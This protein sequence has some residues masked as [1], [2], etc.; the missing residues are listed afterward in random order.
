MTLQLEKMISETRALSID[1]KLELLQVL[2]TDLQQT[3]RFVEET[4]QFWNP[5]ATEELIAAQTKPVITD[6]HTLSA[7][8]W[9]ENETADKIN[10]FIAA[11]R[12]VALLKEA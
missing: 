7:N 6:I 5:Q 10:E 4:N 12:R 9:P 2:S 3:Y 11:Q 8:F 1:E